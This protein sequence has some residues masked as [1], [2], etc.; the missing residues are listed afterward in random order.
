LIC[1]LAFILIH[2][3][4]TER[5]TTFSYEIPENWMV[6]ECDDEYRQLDLLSPKD[7]PAVDCNDKT[8][9][10]G[11]DTD[12]K[13]I[14][15]DGETV[16]SS[17]ESVAELLESEQ[18]YASEC[19]VDEYKGVRVVISTIHTIL[20][21]HKRYDFTSRYPVTIYHYANE[22]DEFVNKDAFNSVLDSIQF[23]DT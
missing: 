11:L 3:Q 13:I 6:L 20:E 2:A 9:L 4:R 1:G 23:N 18:W 12:L 16:C 17:P 22:Q 14:I 15:G 21:K 5:H 10:I 7:D 8:N 19:S